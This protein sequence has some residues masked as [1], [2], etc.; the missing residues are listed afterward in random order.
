MIVVV[1]IGLLAA[2]AIPSFLKIRQS[3]QDKAVYNNLRQIATA[4]Q[5]YML[6]F[7]LSTVTIADLYPA[8]LKEPENVAGEKYPTSIAMPDTEVKATGVGG[9]RTIVYIF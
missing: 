2:L 6:E 7:G 9:S 1:I 8:Y 3:A 5:T 4:A